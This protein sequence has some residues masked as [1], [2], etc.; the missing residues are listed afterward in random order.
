LGHDD[1]V[2]IRLAMAALL[3][4]AAV[5]LAVWPHELGHASVAW[6][7]G[8]KADA[9]RT[10]TRWYLA[11]SVAGGVDEEC[12]VRRGGEAPAFMALAGIAVN[13]LLIGLAPILGR[14]WLQTASERIRWGFIATLLWALANYAEAF[15]YLV[16]NTLWLKADLRIVVDASGVSRWLWTAAGLILGTV[17]ARALAGPV[18]R[19]AAALAGPGAS[20]RLWRRAFAGYVL[21]VSLAAVLSRIFLT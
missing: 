2:K 12:L 9:W 15:S 8:C 3:A 17:I 11:G 1:A 20:E 5:Y 14:W 6:L 10:G 21:A 13:L 19:A 7:Y 4:V 16:L 18:G